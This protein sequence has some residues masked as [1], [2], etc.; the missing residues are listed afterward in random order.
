LNLMLPLD[1]QIQRLRRRIWQSVTSKFAKMRIAGVLAAG[2]TSDDAR[3]TESIT[4]ATGARF[5]K[6]VILQF[7]RQIT[8]DRRP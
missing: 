4:S 2:D 1:C 8:L 7:I 3:H 6:D 5:C